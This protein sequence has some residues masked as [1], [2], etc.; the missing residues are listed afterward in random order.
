METRPEYYYFVNY[1]GELKPDRKSSEVKIVFVCSALRGW[2]LDPGF[3]LSGPFGPLDFAWVLQ[4][5][6]TSVL[7]AKGKILSLK[8]KKSPI[9]DPQASISKNPEHN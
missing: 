8:K 1:D 5:M 2:T 9:S 7:V 6:Y 4:S 3:W